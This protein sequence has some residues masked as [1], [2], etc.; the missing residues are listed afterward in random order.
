[1]KIVFV[2]HRY[3]PNYTSGTEIYTYGI[4]SALRDAGHQISILCAEKWD[5]GDSNNRY[6]VSWQD[7]IYQG[8]DVRR[9][10]LNWRTAPDPH[11]YLFDRNP[12]IKHITVDFVRQQEADLVHVTS[13]VNLSSSVI[14]AALS[15]NV[16]VVFTMTDY[17]VI[18]PRTTLQR[19]D[20]SLCDGRE[21]GLTCLKCLYGETKLYR[22]VRKLPDQ[23][24]R[25]MLKKSAEWRSFTV[26]NSS[27]NLISAVQR[28]NI[29]LPNVLEQVKYLV[30]PSHFLADKVSESG[31]VSRD[32]IAVSLHGH[33]VINAR[34]GHEKKPS[35]Q[36]RFGYT[37]HLLPHKGAHILIEAF[38]QLKSDGQ[39]Q[40]FIYGDP[41]ADSEYSKQLFSIRAGNPAIHFKGRFDNQEIGQILQE[42]DVVIVPSICYEN[43]PVTIAEAFVAKTPV[44]AANLGGMAEAV[45]DGV[46][47]LLFEPGD[48]FDL[49]CQMKRLLDEPGLIDRLKEGIEPVKSVEDEVAELETIYSELVNSREG[50]F[51]S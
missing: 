3:L 46:N 15:L 25:H 8:M 39:A 50:N 4:T 48:S 1:M 21:D 37:G 5:D 22:L 31:I 32:R 2:T 7:E 38:N 24:R 34:Q 40:L 19:S 13:C 14:L 23:L 51:G 26:W 33:K 11:G 47:G 18:C 36:F 6:E 10:S 20:K 41:Q 12:E 42:I 17:W 35:S 45:Q 29:N 30:A 16:P 43:A 27:L 9:L 44:I 49:A 28:R